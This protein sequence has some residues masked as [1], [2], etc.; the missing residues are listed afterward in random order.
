MDAMTVKYFQLVVAIFDLR[1]VKATVPLA[2]A[3]LRAGGRTQT[4]LHG[5]SA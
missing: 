1:M 3:P 5:D 2:R 4:Y